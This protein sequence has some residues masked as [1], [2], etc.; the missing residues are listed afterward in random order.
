MSFLILLGVMVLATC[1]GAVGSLF[2][3]FALEKSQK[4]ILVFFNKYLY[5]GIFFFGL[6]FLSYLFLLKDNDVSFL[7]PITSLTYIWSALLAKKYLKEEINNY[8]V[9]G[10]FF[11]ILGVVLLSF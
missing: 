7:F 1:L 11:I 3:K 5:F 4:F 8:K 10:M 6:G 2:F 9:W